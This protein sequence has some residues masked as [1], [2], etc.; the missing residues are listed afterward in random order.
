M[1]SMKYKERSAYQDRS[2]SLMIPLREKGEYYYQ[3]WWEK[4]HRLVQNLQSM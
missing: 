3:I 2:L 4:D 1:M